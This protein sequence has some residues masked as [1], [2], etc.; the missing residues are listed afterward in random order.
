[1]ASVAMARSASP[2]STMSQICVG[3]PWCSTRRTFGYFFLNAAT[4]FGSA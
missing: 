2:A 4:A 1:M 3:L